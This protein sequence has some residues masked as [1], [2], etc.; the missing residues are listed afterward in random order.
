VLP[1]VPISS[2]TLRGC[3]KLAFQFATLY[4]IEVDTAAMGFVDL[5]P[6][7]FLV[8]ETAISVSCVPRMVEKQV[9]ETSKNKNKCTYVWK[10]V[11][12]TKRCY[13]HTNGESF[14]Q[15]L[16]CFSGCRFNEPQ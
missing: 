12:L 4:G 9:H 6:Y 2:C 16:M 14:Q 13:R 8:E 3:G 7:A 10:F 11:I 15:G 1:A 5:H